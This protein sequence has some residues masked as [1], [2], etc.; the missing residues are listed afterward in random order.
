MRHK[1]WIG[2]SE[3]EITSSCTDGKVNRNI[4]LRNLW[5]VTVGFVGEWLKMGIE[6]L[7]S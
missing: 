1:M 2:R 5:L 3:E 4:V 6:R 7:R